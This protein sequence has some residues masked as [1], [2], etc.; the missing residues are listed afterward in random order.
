[1]YGWLFPQN[2]MIFSHLCIYVFHRSLYDSSRIP[3]CSFRCWLPF[4]RISVQYLW[5]CT[6]NLP[7]WW[8]YWSWLENLHY[9]S[10]FS[11]ARIVEISF[12]TFPGLA[13]IRCPDPQLSNLLVCF[14]TI[15]LNNIRTT[16]VYLSLIFLYVWLPIFYIIGLR[17]TMG[18]HFIIPCSSP[19]FIGLGFEEI[20]L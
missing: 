18:G 16:R 19:D 20:A 13:S 6:Q 10:F 17:P 9:L 8:N 12:G 11:S 4:L 15:F 5:F 3:F 14:L 1:M 7:C 2:L